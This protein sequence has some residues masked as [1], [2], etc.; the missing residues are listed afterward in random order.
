MQQYLKKV[1]ASECI[2]RTVNKAQENA[3]L[4]LCTYHDP[5]D[6][7]QCSVAKV[8]E[9]MEGFLDGEEGYSVKCKQKLKTHYGDDITI[10]WY[11]STSIIR[12]RDSAHKILLERWV[13]DQVTAVQNQSDR[14]IDMAAS[15][16]LN[17]IK[18]TVYD[19]DLYPTREETKNGN[20]MSHDSLKRFLNHLLDRKVR[21]FEVTKRIYFHRLCYNISI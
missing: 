15:I 11:G 3:F 13:N 1:P 6:K 4:K 17:D 20:T 9:T 14:I 10:T 5:S 8:L 18:L 12:F 16:I 21:G 7:C 2:G 19:L